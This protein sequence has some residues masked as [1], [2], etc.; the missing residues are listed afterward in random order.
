ML[1]YTIENFWHSRLPSGRLGAFKALM[2]WESVVPELPTFVEAPLSKSTAYGDRDDPATS[3]LILV[4]AAGA[5]GKST[6]ARQIASATGAVYVDLAKADPVGGNTLSGGLMKS[7]LLADWEAGAATVLID[8]LDE[9]RLKVTQDGFNA[10][11]KDVAELAKERSTPT[12]LFGRTG[13]IQEAWLLLADEVPVTVLEIGYYTPE[14]ATRF[15]MALLRQRK[16]DYPF[17]D[18]AERA[19]TLLLD[20]LR[21]DVGGDGDR[22]AGYAPVLQAVAEQVARDANPAALIA[23]I[24]RGEQPVTLQTIITAILER[25]QMKLASLAFEDASL[26]TKLYDPNEQLTRLVARVYGQPTPPLP[27][28]SANDAQIYANALETW[29]ADHPFLDGGSAPVSAIFDA[30]I[31]GIALCDEQTARAATSRELARGVAANPF[32]AEFYFA[33]QEKG[34]IR[35]EHIGIIYASLRARLS[36]G[37]EA[38]LSIEGVESEDELERLK[39]EIEITLVRVGSDRPRVLSFDTEQTGVVRLGSFVEDVEVTAPYAD[40]EIGGGREAILVSPVAIQ[41]G[42]LLIRAERLIVEAQTDRETGAISLEAETADTTDVSNVPLSNGNV[43][44]TVSWQDDG[45]YPWTN[46]RSEPTPV[47]DPRTAEALRRFRKFVISFRS[48]SKG[49][50]KRFARKLEHERMTKG[51]GSA[52]LHHMLDTGIVST[53]GSMYTLYPD[54]LAQVADASYGS[55]MAR[56]FSDGTIAFVQ[57]AIT[58]AV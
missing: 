5:V 3:P 45:A 15:A 9:A 47:Q 58:G 41:V 38:S 37:D 31:A 6:L 43:A 34:Y 20:G 33:A 26:K 42:H 17:M 50:L 36:I 25:E 55:I 16:P 24:E 56:H 13:A 52:V 27:P 14:L 8:G 46:F 54:K 12:V 28:M 40:V 11:I 29:T 21:Q 49:A 18:A 30:V 10:F 32:L 48:H 51:T 39:A 44:L 35:P 22:F 7:R 1:N 2:G 19:I 57:E 4:S 23:K 53:D